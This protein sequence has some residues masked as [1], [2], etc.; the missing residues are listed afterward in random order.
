MNNIDEF[1]SADFWKYL[2]ES[3]WL[4]LE[5]K[6]SWSTGPENSSNIDC[7][8]LRLSGLIYTLF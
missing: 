5:K 7:V 3:K 1:R 8:T 2:F 6:N 4:P